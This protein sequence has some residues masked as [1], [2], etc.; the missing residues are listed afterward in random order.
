MNGLNEVSLSKWKGGIGEC[1]NTVRM[2]FGQLLPEINSEPEITFR[3]NALSPKSY[4]FI[5][6]WN[7]NVGDVTMD[8][9]ILI[10]DAISGLDVILALGCNTG[11]CL[12]KKS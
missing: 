8:Y 6:I 7:Q 11:E 12:Y 5:D 1:D 9:D 3:I 10:L 4:P 2:C